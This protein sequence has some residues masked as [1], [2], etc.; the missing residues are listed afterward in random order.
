MNYQF[1]NTLDLDKDAFEKLIDSH[2][3]D[4]ERIL[5]DPRKGKETLLSVSD[6]EITDIDSYRIRQMEPWEY[7]LKK[8]TAFVPRTAL[9]KS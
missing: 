8:N 7:A 6:D 4:T 3:E 9:A 2:V 5:K 1:F